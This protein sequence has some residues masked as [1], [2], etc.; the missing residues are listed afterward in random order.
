[1]NMRDIDP[2]L[3]Q[4]LGIGNAFIHQRIN[5]RGHQESRR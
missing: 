3:I 5:T 2:F 1:M 4:A